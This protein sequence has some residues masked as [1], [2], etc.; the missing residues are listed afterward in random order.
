MR[1]IYGVSGSSHL[2]PQEK[3]HFKI[4][5]SRAAFDFQYEILFALSYKRSP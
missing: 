3:G 2:L 1:G 4:L 5:E